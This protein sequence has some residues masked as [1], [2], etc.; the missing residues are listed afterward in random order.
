MLKMLPLKIWRT[1]AATNRITMAKDR[2]AGRR[3]PIR[4]APS[5][6]AAM[7][8]QAFSAVLTARATIA[9][10]NPA[11]ARAAAPDADYFNQKD[12]AGGA[13]NDAEGDEHDGR[14]P[15]VDEEPDLGWPEMTN[16]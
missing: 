15:D 6:T 12:W 5:R 8:T 16:Q 7:T 4:T 14:E 3:T 1:A 9:M 13:M 2:W 10:P 11:S